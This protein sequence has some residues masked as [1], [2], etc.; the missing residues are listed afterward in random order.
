M[1]YVEHSQLLMRILLIY[2]RK[3]QAYLEQKHVQQMF[4]V[5]FEIAK[6]H[7]SEQSLTLF[8]KYITDIDVSYII[9]TNDLV[10]NFLFSLKYRYKGLKIYEVICVK[11]SFED[12]DPKRI[13]VSLRCQLPMMVREG[14]RKINF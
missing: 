6:T 4:Q 10:P 3:N 12:L 5:H 7:L 8:Y 14:R 13:R 11:K 2:V 9:I 1:N